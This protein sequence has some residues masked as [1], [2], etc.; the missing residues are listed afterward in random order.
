MKLLVL[1]ALL[2]TLGCSTTSSPSSGNS[3]PS[4]GTQQDCIAAGGQCLVGHGATMYAKEG[5]ANTCD[6]NPG[7]SPAGAFCCISSIDAGA[8]AHQD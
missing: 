3:S 5:P 7:C 6:C 1:A 8:D 2:V 4:Y